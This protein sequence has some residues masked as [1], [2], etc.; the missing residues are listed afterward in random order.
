VLPLAAITLS[1]VGLATAFAA[2]FISFVSPCVWPLVPAYLSYVS[3]VAY[4]DLS[5]NARRVALATAFFVA[6]F[7]IVFTALGIGAAQFGGFLFD[8]KRTLE[9]IGGVLVIGMGLVLVGIGG[10]LFAREARVHLRSKPASLGGALVAGMAFAIGWT[11]CIG[12]TLTAI[13]AV[14]GTGETSDAA[15][16]LVAYS[17]GLGVPFLLA[18]LFMSSTISALGVLRRHA[19][20]VNRVAGAVLV[21]VGVLLATGQLTEI[22]RQLSTTW[23]IG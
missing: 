6:G 4:E 12:P 11:P 7:T 13:L 5:A 2:G 9:V 18:G 10:R 16:L 1:P 8:N 22:T 23:A 14:A 15:A 21:L 19:V 20:W 17:L 3:G